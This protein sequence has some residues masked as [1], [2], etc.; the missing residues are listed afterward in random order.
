MPTA[1]RRQ[2]HRR[3]RSQDVEEAATEVQSDAVTPEDAAVEVAADERMEE[4]FEEV[5]AAEDE[6]EG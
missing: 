6:E 1:T 2:T 5:E 3:L 4:E